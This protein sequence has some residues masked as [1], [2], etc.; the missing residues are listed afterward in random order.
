M[1]LD[2]TLL[3]SGGNLPPQN[4]ETVA[5]AAKRGIAIVIVT[6]RRFDSARAIAGELPCDV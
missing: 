6:G 4:V 1:D 3:D 2:G 5:E